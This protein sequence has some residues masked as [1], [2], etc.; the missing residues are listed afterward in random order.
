MILAKAVILVA[1]DS[2]DS[3]SQSSFW[4]VKNDLKF[5]ETHNTECYNQMLLDVSIARQSNPVEIKLFVNRCCDISLTE[6]C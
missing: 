5:L 6:Y 3:V 2:R 4:I 1:C